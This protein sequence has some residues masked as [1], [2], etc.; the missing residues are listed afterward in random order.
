MARAKASTALANVEAEAQAAVANIENQIG[1]GGG[2][3]VSTKGKQFTLPDGTSDNE[4]TAVIVAFRTAHRY[5]IEPYVEGVIQ[6][7]SCFAIGENPKTLVP[8]ENSP[9]R[10]AD[11]CTE[12]WAN[13]WE[14]AGG[15]RKG[16]M[17][18][19]SRIVALLSP[20]AKPDTEF[21]LLSISTTALTRFDNYVR[22]L[23]RKTG[24]PPIGVVTLFKFDG[25]VGYP[26]V[27]FGEPQ[28]NPRWK[29]MWPRVNDAIEL[30]ERE[31]DVQAEPEPK[32]TTKKTAKKVAR[33]R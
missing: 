13:Q 19:E 33:K 9:D 8:S 3:W 32:K 15:G 4:M 31:P 18:K 6:Q 30:L 12:C 27:T 17:C 24:Q 29:E 14:S 28:P 25:D 11:T 2:N 23:V 16:K 22:G 10:Q 5:F 20:D 1:S 7:P 26:S 21:V